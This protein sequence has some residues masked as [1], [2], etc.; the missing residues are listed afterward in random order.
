MA[1]RLPAVSNRFNAAWPS[2]EVSEYA[3]TTTQT[4]A[5]AAACDHILL[6]I[7]AKKKN[8]TSAFMQSAAALAA[9]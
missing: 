5:E 7:A 8:G 1:A 3:V 9:P 2:A 4:N 6:R